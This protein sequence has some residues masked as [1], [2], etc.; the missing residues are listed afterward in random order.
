MV[1]YTPARRADEQGSGLGRA[2]LFLPGAAAELP[3][4]T[5]LFAC[6]GGEPPVFPTAPPLLLPPEFAD[7]LALVLPGVL[8]LLPGLPEPPLPLELPL[9]F[10][11][12]E[13]D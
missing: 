6:P 10:E 2:Y 12:A 3:G 9:P 11:P 13:P 4:E 7:P 8:P 5:G 1:E